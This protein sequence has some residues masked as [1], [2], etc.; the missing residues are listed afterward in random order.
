MQI[1]KKKK[2]RPSVCYLGT[3]RVHNI[4][5]LNINNR[6]EN[7]PY[8]TPPIIWPAM[9]AIEVADCIAAFICWK[10]SRSVILGTDALKV[11]INNS[12]LIRIIII[13][14]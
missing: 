7:T 1:K 5:R 12:S 2:L 11:T 14:T 6:N 13:N 8:A 3:N 9:L 4:I 10:C